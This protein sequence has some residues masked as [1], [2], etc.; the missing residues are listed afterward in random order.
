MK[1]ITLEDGTKISPMLHRCVE[2][3]QIYEMGYV[4]ADIY[5]IQEGGFCPTCQETLPHTTITETKNDG[6][7]VLTK[8]DYAPKTHKIVSGNCEICGCF[9]CA[10]T[11]QI[12][13]EWHIRDEADKP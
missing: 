8:L 3:G 1:P 9:P 10:H 11:Y 7:T 2:C 13:C 12:G 5:S 4:H 6:K